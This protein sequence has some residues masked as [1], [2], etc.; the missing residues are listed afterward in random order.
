MA[1]FLGALLASMLTCTPSLDAS[2]TALV[3]SLMQCQ[4]C[5][6]GEFDAVV[7]LGANAVP[8]LRDLVVN[9]P[10]TERISRRQH[11]LASIVAQLPPSGIPPSQIVARQV[12]EY[13]MLYRVRS[14]EALAAIGTSAARHALCA[15][16]IS[17]P[18]VPAVVAAIDSAL[19][20]LSATCP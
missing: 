8:L 10:P 17:P 12:D 14:A 1:P 18:P 7:A 16:R 9:D 2:G 3:F 19:A 11:Y 15:G 6:N 5:N 13:R 20:H 4:E